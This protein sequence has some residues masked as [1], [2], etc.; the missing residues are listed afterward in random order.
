MN[1][2]TIALC[3]GGFVAGL[4]G[5]YF[6][7]KPKPKKD[8]T[9]EQPILTHELLIL[10]RKDLGMGRGKIAAQCGHATMIIFEKA[11][12]QFPDQMSLWKEK[13]TGPTVLAVQTEEEM[14]E[15]KAKAKKLGCVTGVVHDAGRTQI[16]AGSTTCCSIFGPKEIVQE[17]EKGLISLK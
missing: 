6:I 17:F 7:A 2:R 14:Q 1:P 13:E 8:V 10:V 3:V 9:V 15:I 16:A 4:S 11:M 5:A 12:K